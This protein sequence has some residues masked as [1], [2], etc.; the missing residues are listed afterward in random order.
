MSA[1]SLEQPQEH[2]RTPVQVVVIRDRHDPDTNVFVDLLKRAV[3][4]D[5]DHYSGYVSESLGIGIRVLEPKDTDDTQWF[6]EALF[7]A[8][9][10]TVVLQI[11]SH[12]NNKITATQAAILEHPEAG[13]P[14]KISVPPPVAKGKL[15]NNQTDPGHVEP[16]LHPLVATLAVLE[17]IRQKLSNTMEDV[18][19]NDA[20]RLFISHAKSDG[21]LLAVSLVDFCRRATTLFDKILHDTKLAEYFYD[22]ESIENNTD[23]RQ[24][25]RDAACQGVLIALRTDDYDTRFWCRQE[26]VWAEENR[27]P[28]VVVD[29][30]KTM[31]TDGGP[32]HFDCAT[33]VRV[34]D[35][36][37]IRILLQAIAAHIRYLLL[38]WRVQKTPGKNAPI[39]VLPRHPT[40]ASVHSLAEIIKKTL[41]RSAVIVYPGEAIAESSCEVLEGYLSSASKTPTQVLSLAQWETT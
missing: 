22:A 13:K 8:A 5:T 6:L 7:G 35:G 29:V 26:F 39:A 24:S 36:N 33:T 23:W 34:S 10:L 37:L 38:K 11:E 12:E 40:P 15:Q 1:S 20:A 16:G 9:A 3:E 25:L 30:R 2:R 21:A 32:L 27:R 28:I 14:I 31:M 41:T 17:S 4:G 19:A 18:D